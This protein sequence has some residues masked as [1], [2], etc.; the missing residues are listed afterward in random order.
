VTQSFDTDPNA[1]TRLL[2]AEDDL[3]TR[4][5]LKKMLEKAG[6]RADFVTDGQEAIDALKQ[7]DYDLVLM[8]CF[9]PR[10]D[11]FAATRMLRRSTSDGFNPEIPVI[12]MTGLT[13]ESDRERCM[14]AGMDDHIGKPVNTDELVAAIE[15]N[16]GGVPRSA[17]APPVQATA[18]TPAWDG[19]FLDTLIERFTAEIPEVVDSLRQAVE[20][21]DMAG[22]ER[23]GHRLR[24][25]SDILD[26]RS[27]SARSGK[28][29]QAGKA[30]DIEQAG[31]LASELV[32]ELQK[33]AAALKPAY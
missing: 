6:Y 10:L 22:L 7:K 17:D 25:A 31:R 8:D 4:L 9:M 29:E 2:V 12:A 33:M 13:G 21:S 18:A 32:T 27:L 1:G 5:V 20:G 28:L 16:L 3:V 15:K 24:G 26:I 11:G 19:D 30:G 23:L 14:A